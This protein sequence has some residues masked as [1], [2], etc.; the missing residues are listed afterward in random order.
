MVSVNLALAFEESKF[1]TAYDAEVRKRALAE[2]YRDFHSSKSVV[3][4]RVL[5][6]FEYDTLLHLADVLLLNYLHE[7]GKGAMD[8]VGMK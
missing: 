4:G 7:V 6:V 3:I 1:G 2:S 8:K 5:H